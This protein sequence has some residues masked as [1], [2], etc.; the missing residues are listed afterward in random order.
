MSAGTDGDEPGPRHLRIIGVAD[1][2]SY[3]KWA[4]A[5]LGTAPARWDAALLVLSTPVTVSD[6]QL[7]SALAGSGL[8]AVTRTTYDGLVARL[9]ADPPDAVL[10]ATRGPLARVVA[11]AVAEAAPGVVILTGLPGISIP[12]TDKALTFR[13]QCDLFVVHSHREARDFA[14]LAEELG[15]RQTFALSSLPFA[16]GAGQ[17]R[18]AGSGGPGSRGEP[19]S[20]PPPALSAGDPGAGA[21]TATAA[22]AGDL[23]F[24][25]QAVVP[26]ARADRRR[27]VALLVR[28][29]RAHPERRVVLKLRAVAGEHQTHAEAD[30]YPDLL[31][32]LGPAPANL[33]VS[34]AA[35]RAALDTAEGLVTVSSTAAIEALARGIPVIAL[36]TFGVSPELINVVFGGSGLFGDEEDVVARRFRHPHPS[37]TRDN[38]LHDPADDDWGCALADLVARRRAGT[39]PPRSPARR[40]GGRL[41]DI[42]ERKRVL[43]PLDRTF[44]GY[45]ALVVGMPLRG[46]YV[47]AQRIRGWATGEMPRPDVEAAVASTAP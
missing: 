46:A 38:Y 22:T 14:A 6:A 47:S 1:T 7:A 29:A 26:L 35:M 32:G 24:A 36:D 4:A 30:P 34:T 44:A 18:A 33:V 21:P 23:V 16:T 27:I 19:G 45:A 31:A 8:D 25:A 41:R 10:V 15:L 2:D 39:L 12:A 40:R 20:V 17:V 9:A 5:L 28:A 11:R 43:G 42:W 3:V 13:A 37:W